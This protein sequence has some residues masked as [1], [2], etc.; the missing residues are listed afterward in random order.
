MPIEN[1]KQLV[2]Y[3]LRIG[4]TSL[5]L[6][7]RLTE[8]CGHAP[9][10]EED[11]AM[12]NMSLDLIGQARIMLSYAGE[13]E[14]KDRTE[15]DLAY[16]RDERAYTNLLLAELP[17]GDFAQTMARHFLLTTYLLHIYDALKTSKNET[18]RGFGE[19]SWKEIAYHVR[20]SSDWMLR[21]GDGTEES[22]Q[23]LQ[24]A[25]DELWAYTD[26]LFH[27]D[28]TDLKLAES[29]IAPDLSMIAKKW[30]KDVDAIFSKAR[31][32]RPSISGFMKDGSR[33]GLHTEHLGYILAEMQ[34]LPRAYPDAKW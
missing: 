14:G 26:D 18:L 16:H 2:E 22:N 28:E 33:K 31:I 8:W 12:S 7:Q 15:D 9:E 21:L 1:N 24:Q 6:G 5:I 30:N 34:F 27:A 17:N 23:R 19:K 13:A 4:D 3:F 32:N 10:L 29:G 25:V 20:H 11:I